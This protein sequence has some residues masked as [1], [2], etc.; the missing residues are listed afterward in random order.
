LLAGCGGGGASP[1]APAFIVG[2][3][4]PP[5]APLPPKLSATL[6]ISKFVVRSVPTTAGHATYFVTLQASETSGLGG[7]DLS[8]ITI[9]DS[10]GDSDVGC[11]GRVEPGTTW[12]MD[13]QSFG[14][15]APGVPTNREV[16]SVSVAIEFV[17]DD[18]TRGE[19]TRSVETTR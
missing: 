1:V 14:Y 3:N 10:T 5:P 7:A 18:G 15:C 8:T 2:A 11:G 13:V 12:D 17:T 4:A 19:L 6:Q 16:P 9:T